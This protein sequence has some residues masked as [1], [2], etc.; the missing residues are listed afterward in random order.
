[1]RP[2]TVLIPLLLA[3]ALTAPVFAAEDIVGTL[4]IAGQGQVTAAPDTAFVTSGVMTEGATAR[5]ALDANTAAMTSLMDT[6]KAA[7]IEARDIQT[8]GF[9]VAPN[10]VYSDTRDANGY[11][12]PPKINGYQVSNT[13]S[14]RVRKLADLGAV[15]D[16][17]V[18]V[19]ANT[20]NGISFAVEDPT[21]LYDEARKAAFAD[22]RRKAEL[23]A[24]ASGSD[25]GKIQSINEQ[26][27]LGQPQ[28]YM[29]KTMAMDAASAPVPVSA[30]ELSYSINVNVTWV[31]DD[32]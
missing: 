3:T 10:Y 5:E 14:V 28:P 1:M 6:L 19:G 31:L 23:Y 7:G 16:K 24:E 30:G 2:F 12:L 27:D 26:Q 11:T 15:L 13:V 17:A 20:I 18:T 4:S 9:T 22:A 21:K 29:M 32:K 25:L 8:S